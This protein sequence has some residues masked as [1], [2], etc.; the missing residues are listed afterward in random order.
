MEM[1]MTRLTASFLAI[2]ALSLPGAAALADALQDELQVCRSL[3]DDDARLIC[4][5]GAV[6]RSRK[7]GY[8][9]PAPTKAAAPPPAAPGN[10]PRTE[11]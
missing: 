7:S 1:P 3:T 2:L 8:S 5:D 9:R 4:Y 6:D 11:N 10:S